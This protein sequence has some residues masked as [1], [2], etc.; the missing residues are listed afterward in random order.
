MGSLVYFRISTVLEN[1]GKSLNLE[2]KQYP[3]IEIP[4]KFLRS[5]KVL[6]YLFVWNGNNV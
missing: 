5:L 3:V 6:E 4:L 1:P 2:K